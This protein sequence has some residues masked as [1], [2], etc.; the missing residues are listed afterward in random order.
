M[1]RF[2]Q[3]AG[4]VPAILK[5]DPAV[6]SRQKARLAALRARRDGERVQAALR[7]L[8][9]VASGGD[10]LLPPILECVRAYATIG[11]ICETLRGR[12]GVYRPPA[13]V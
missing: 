10:N 3:A 5:V 12:F 11:E 4:Q 1:N 13:V 8:D 9:G 2:Q 7:A 6:V